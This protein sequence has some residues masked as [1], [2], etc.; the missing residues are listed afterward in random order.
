DSAHRH[1][2]S[3]QFNSL[4]GNIRQLRGFERFL[5][6]PSE[7]EMKNLAR[8]PIVLFNVSE[9]RSDAFII[10]QER[11]RLLRL[12]SLKYSDLRDNVILFFKTI[13]TVNT[14]TSATAMLELNKVLERLWDV[15]VGPILDELGFKQPPS[16]NDMWPR[17]CWIPSGILTLLPIH[18][19]GYHNSTRNAIDRVISSYAAT[20][21]SLA[22]AR[23][24]AERTKEVDSLKVMLLSI[25]PKQTD[26]PYA[27]KEVR[28]LLR[29]MDL[30]A[31]VSLTTIQHPTRQAVLSAIHDHQVVHFACH[32]HSVSDPSQSRLLLRDWEMASLTVS[33]IASLNLQVP[34]LAY[35]SACHTAATIAFRLVDESINLSTA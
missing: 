24:H 22:Y 16:H 31:N 27:E 1:E 18:A 21:K 11:I 33:D 8:Y 32:G 5:L 15:A 23:V 3:K 9:I 4:V 7:S 12:P 28:E 35:L 13:H 29:L 14:K 30:S 26:L 25:R 19:A 2:L 34:Q 10:D 6:G 17:V 20:V